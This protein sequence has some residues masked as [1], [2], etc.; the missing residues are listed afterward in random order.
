MATKSGILATINGFI[1]AIITQSKVRSAYSTVVDEL[2]PNV[3]TDSNDTETYTTK[4]G[5]NID[6][7]I[8]IQK[9]GNSCYIKGTIINNTTLAV[10][11]QNIFT[12][13]SNQ[14]KP[15]ASVNNLTFRAIFG[16]GNNINLYLSDSGL[17]LT[18]SLNALGSYTFNYQFY[19]AQD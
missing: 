19:I 12:W 10:S 9:S 3:V 1:T 13:K 11:P 17:D 6:Y 7:S 2:Y 16:T 18:S 14:F 15:K 8:T 5:S 4:A